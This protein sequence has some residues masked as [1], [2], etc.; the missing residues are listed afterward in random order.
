[1]SEAEAARVARTTPKALRAVV[2]ADNSVFAALGGT[3]PL[4]DAGR[5]KAQRALGQMVLGR[6]AEMAFLS[7][8]RDA[9]SDE[10]LDIVNVS[11][12]GSRHSVD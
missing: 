12:E 5:R 8:F 4:E 9:F 2:S 11:E 10:E 1:M 7:L 3:K 6:A